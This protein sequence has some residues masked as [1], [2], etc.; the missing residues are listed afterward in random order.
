MSLLDVVTAYKHCLEL[1]CANCSNKDIKSHNR[2]SIR[3]LVLLHRPLELNQK[4]D[5]PN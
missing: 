3:I 2:E 5:S 4:V 1:T